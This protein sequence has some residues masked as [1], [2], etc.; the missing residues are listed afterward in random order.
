MQE[1]RVVLSHSSRGET[2]LRMGTRQVRIG[3]DVPGITG[4]L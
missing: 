2:A 3:V 1:R 4:V